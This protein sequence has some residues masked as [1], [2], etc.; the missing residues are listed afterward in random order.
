MN[1]LGSFSQCL[2][3]GD[4]EALG[5]ARSLRRKAVGASILFEILLVVA[6]LLAPL[7]T[8]GVLPRLYNVT[9]LPPYSGGRIVQREHPPTT[10][11]P[12]ARDG[13][14]YFD[15]SSPA[16]PTGRTFSDQPGTS[17][18][19][20][21]WPVSD[22]SFGPGIPFA[23]GDHPA[24]PPPPMTERHEAVRKVS[25]GAMEGSLIHR[26]DPAYPRIAIVGHIT[27][28]VKVRATIG[29]DGRI[30]DWEIVSGNPIF[31]QSTITAI[32]QWRYRPTLL[33]GEPVEVETIIT[34][35]FI[36][37]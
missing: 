30:H 11:H 12:T 18:P 20:V 22:G 9:P 19:D 21:G 34:V 14:R 15:P 32:R 31:A 27:G 2:V 6:M 10:V 24:S 7:I 16:T 4:V 37:N 8:P 35:N 36:L 29:T 26:V 33:N 3:E 25:I 1:D 23:A 5:R 17:A 28:E 13:I